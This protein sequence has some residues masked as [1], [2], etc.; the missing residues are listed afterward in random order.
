MVVKIYHC[1]QF[2]V[3]INMEGSTIP[4]ICLK[5]YFSHRDPAKILSLCL[6]TVPLQYVPKIRFTQ[7]TIDCLIT[8]KTRNAFHNET[9][10]LNHIGADP[11]SYSLSN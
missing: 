10:I 1:L 8:K 6:P 9:V 7:V 5:A 4:R 11:I 3:V 2:I